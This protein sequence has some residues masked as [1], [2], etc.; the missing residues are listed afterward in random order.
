MRLQ[1]RHSTIVVNVQPS[2]GATGRSKAQCQYS[3]DETTIHFEAP[4]KGPNKS[5]IR[6]FRAL[7]RR[8]TGQSWTYK[9]VRRPC[10]KLQ[11]KDSQKEC[12]EDQREVK[13]LGGNPRA[14]LRSPGPP[15]LPSGSGLPSTPASYA[16]TSSC[17]HVEACQTGCPMT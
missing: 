17:P 7:Y 2:Q 12:R 5:P 3:A 15:S 13:E 14:V 6:P 4:N 1:E 9:V 16:N 8:E 10:Y 11:R